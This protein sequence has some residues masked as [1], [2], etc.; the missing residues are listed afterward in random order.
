[1]EQYA[2]KMHLNPGCKEK[3]RKRHEDIWPEACRI[4]KGRGRVGLFDPS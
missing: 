1:M 2:F 4:A 3:Y